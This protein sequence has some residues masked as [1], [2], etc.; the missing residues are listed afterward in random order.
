[1]PAEVVLESA[2][3]NPAKALG[4][5]GKIGTNSK[6]SAADLIFV[7]LRNPSLFP[8]ND[9]ISSLCYS[10]NGSE[11]DSVMINGNFVMKNG[12]LTTVDVER[13]FYEINRIKAKYI[14]RRDVLMIGIILAAGDGKRLKT[15]GK[16]DYCKPL[17][18]VNGKRISENINVFSGDV[19]DIYFIEQEE[20]LDILSFRFC[21]SRIECN[22]KYSSSESS[23]Q[24]DIIA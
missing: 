4:M 1:M 9:I 3:V 24:S 21:I 17:I 23:R 6:G 19:I 18:K 20:K 22:N 16:E 5:S 14:Y 12:V 2:T 13:V 15:S 10:A 8:N 11:V 7:D